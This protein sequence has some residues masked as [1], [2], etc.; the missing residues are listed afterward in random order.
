MEVLVGIAIGTFLVHETIG[1]I[2][3]LISELGDLIRSALKAGVRIFQIVVDGVVHIV[4]Y[5]K[6]GAVAVINTCGEVIKH[7]VTKLTELL[8]KAFEAGKSCIKFIVNGVVRIVKF[9]KNGVVQICNKVGDVLMSGNVK[10][11]EFAELAA[12][13]FSFGSSH[14]HHH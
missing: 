6:D 9:L 8:C 2:K 11:E 3:H 10:V 7:G 5:L 14:P 1:L 13:L 4:K 12:R